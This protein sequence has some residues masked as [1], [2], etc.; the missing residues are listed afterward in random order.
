MPTRSFY[1]PT[2]DLTPPD[3]SAYRAGNTGIDY[4]TTFDSGKPGPH[5]MVNALTHGNEICGALTHRFLFDNGIRPG[6]GKLTLSFANVDA[7]GR[8]ETCDPFASRFVDE[9]FNRLWTDEVLDGPRQSRELTR[10][11][12][13]RPLVA[14]ADYLLDIHS[15][16]LPSPP[17]LLCGLQDKSLAMARAM[18]FPAHIMRDPGHESGKRMRD[19]DAFDDPASPKTAMLIEAGQHW[20]ASS[21]DVAVQTTLRFLRFSGVVDPAVLDEHIDESQAGPQKVIEVTGPITIKTRGFRF[22]EDYVG[23]EVIEEKGTLIAYDGDEEVRTPFDAC[24][25]I[26]PGRQLEPGLTAVR[27]GR[28]V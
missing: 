18:G 12:A 6:A 13:L 25:L 5:V 10:A 15:M 8:F 23:L 27:L 14:E 7:F 21:M 20:A 22:V 19:Y 28:V 24:V 17:L 3:I 1:E 11:R 2:I 9:D 4:V 26:M 16:F